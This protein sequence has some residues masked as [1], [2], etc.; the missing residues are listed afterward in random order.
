LVLPL[1]LPVFA[2][3]F[4]LMASNELQASHDPEREI[5]IIEDWLDLDL[6]G[7]AWRFGLR[8]SS[9]SPPDPTVSTDGKASEGLSHRFAEFTMGKS[10]LRVGTFT[11]LFGRGMVLRSFENRDLRV[12]TNLDGLLLEQEEENWTASLLTG[13]VENGQMET[14]ERKRGDRISG[15]DFDYRLNCHHFGGSALVMED[16]SEF[17]PQMQSLRAGFQNETFSLDWEGG[18]KLRGPGREN[19]QGHVLEASWQSGPFTA[20]GALKQYENFAL[21]THD[22]KLMNQPPVLL[23][24]ARATLLNRHPH[25]LDPEDEQGILLDLS[26]STSK[27]IFTVSYAESRS[28]EEGKLDGEFRESFLEWD[29]TL[30][31]LDAPL[32]L[33]LDFQQVAASDSLARWSLDYYLTLVMDLH[34][35]SE[36]GNWTFQW[37]HQHKN[38]DIV[39]QYDDEFLMLEYQDWDGWS[40]SLYTE[41]LNWSRDQQIWERQEKERTRWTGVQFARHLGKHHELRLGVGGRRS[42]YLCVGGV[43]RYEPAFDGVELFLL[44]RF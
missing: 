34:I 27:G 42:G 25:E 10:R 11:K 2:Q 19:G 16:G 4:S 23:H 32:H 38:S 3:D 43:C 6:Y 20:F 35:S 26:A 12:D 7:E 41:F 15:L 18:R 37:E 1:A 40:L 5:D 28:L 33:M 9:F 22:G 31:A 30:A 36:H 13:R 29:G 14:G 8:Y 17:S 44:S 21:K 39:G 24:D